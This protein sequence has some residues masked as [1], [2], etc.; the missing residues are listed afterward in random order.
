MERMIRV[1]GKGKL[2][3]RPDTI[4]LCLALEGIRPEY[5]HLLSNVLNV[6]TEKNRMIPDCCPAK[7]AKLKCYGK[8][9]DLF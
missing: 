4:R 9:E 5:R 8:A 6:W 3:L 1:T 2:A 7:P